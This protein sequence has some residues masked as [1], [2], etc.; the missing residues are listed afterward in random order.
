MKKVLLI[1]PTR[2][3]TIDRTYSAGVLDQVKLL[4]PE[5]R[6]K[7]HLKTKAAMNLPSLSLMILSALTPIDFDVELVD[8]KISEVDFDSPV[9]LVAITVNTTIANRAYYLATEFRKKGAKVVVGG[10]HPSALPDEALSYSDAV[11]VGEA[12]SVWADVL[13]D[14]LIGRLGGVYKSELIDMER[15]YVTPDRSVLD[16]DQYIFD[17]ALELSRGCPFNCDFCSGHIVSGK[18]YR[19]REIDSVLEQVSSIDSDFLWFTDDN[20]TGNPAHTKRFLRELKK[21]NK[22]WAGSASVLLRQDKELLDLVIDSGCRFLV[23]GLESLSDLVLSS[24]NKK[25]NRVGDYISLVKYLQDAGVIVAASFI[26]GFDGETYDSI[27]TLQSFVKENDYV[28]YIEHD[29]P[30]L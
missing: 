2:E 9:D 21:L 26:L 3:R 19:V 1:Q 29:F 6:L 25:M 10:I 8:E 15:G 20:I 7:N 11:V 24:V 18:K 27:K 28:F 16:V 30:Q 12:E 22:Q 13:N 5:G 23:L 4:L 14:F 17:N